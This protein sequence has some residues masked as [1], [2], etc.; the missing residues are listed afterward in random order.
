MSWSPAVG[1]PCQETGGFQVLAAETQ[2]G[3]VIGPG[4]VFRDG[5]DGIRDAVAAVA[6]HDASAQHVHDRAAGGGNVVRGDFRAAH[7]MHL[8]TARTG[9]GVFIASQWSLPS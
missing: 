5:T 1:T 9:R 6:F 8:K 4:Q 3:V 7:T 2:E